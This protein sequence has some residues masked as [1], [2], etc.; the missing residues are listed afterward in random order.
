MILMYTFT[1]YISPSVATL[2]VMSHKLMDSGLEYM[3]YLTMSGLILASM[4][5]TMSPSTGIL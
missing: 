5:T 1:V 3:Q 4:F 2:K